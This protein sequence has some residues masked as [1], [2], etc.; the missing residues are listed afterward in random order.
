MKIR[1]F[2]GL[3]L[4]TLCAQAQEDDYYPVKE[5][6]RWTYKMSTGAQWI[7]TVTGKEKI[8]GVDCFIIE[9]EVGGQK[10]Q[11]EWMAKTD[12][13]VQYLKMS[14]MANGQAQTFNPPVV[15]IRYP[16]EQGQEW[17]LGS[18]MGG[19]LTGVHK[20]EEEVKV[21]AGPFTAWKV[22]MTYAAGEKNSQTRTS[23]YAKGVGCVKQ[24]MTMQEGDQKMELN[25]ELTRFTK[26][27]GKGGGQ[28][29]KSKPP[30]SKTRPSISFRDQDCFP[31]AN[32][33]KWT[34][35]QGDQERSVRVRGTEKVGS[36][37]AFA[38]VDEWKEG[39]QVTHFVVDEEGVKVVRIKNATLD[40][41]LSEN[42][43]LRLKFGAKKGDTWLW[44]GTI[45]RQ[46]QTTT[47]AHEGVEEIEVPAGTF[48]GMKITAK[49]KTSTGEFGVTRWYAPDIGLVKEV[50]Q[51][52][53][54]EMIVELVK[55]EK[56]EGVSATRKEESGDF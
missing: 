38:L 56:P 48:T 37:E 7:A 8:K 23:W 39:S 29:D 18:F 20:G 5:G 14:S 12:E 42:P 27:A 22:V 25:L 3:L 26:E 47:Y 46:E 24:V 34:Y 36:V 35:K 4:A 44:K 45:N 32:G 43:F 2:A 55:F 49:A 13:G 10:V 17:K 19:T 53:G 30:P 50:H 16:I 11:K 1:T 15:L 51:A 28:S 40:E 52:A 31:I 6:Y 54:G 9:T 21:P 33:Y 41:D